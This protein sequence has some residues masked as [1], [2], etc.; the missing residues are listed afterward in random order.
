MRTIYRV[1]AALSL[2]LAAI[3]CDGTTTTTMPDMKGLEV[4]SSNGIGEI[5][6][7]APVATVEVPNLTA[8]IGGEGVCYVS[9]STGREQN[10]RYRVSKVLDLSDP[11]NYE[12]QEHLVDF[13]TEVPNKSVDF[14]VGRLPR[15][16]CNGHYQIDC[17]R[18]N[19]L[20]TYKHLEISGW[21]CPSPRPTPTPTPPSQCVY[22][23]WVV[24]HATEWTPCSEG[25]STRTVTYKRYATPSRESCPPEYK[26]EIEVR[27]CHIEYGFCHVSNKGQD[28][29][30]NLVVSYKAA[31]TG[32][33]LHTDINKFCPPDWAVEIGEAPGL[34]SASKGDNSCKLEGNPLTEKYCSCTYPDGQTVLDV[35]KSCN[36]R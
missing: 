24:D 15:G 16:L 10:I 29:N 12:K 7:L 3:A 34:Q 23:D 5:T 30:W 11:A 9:N 6:T 4:S 22:G 25:M 21:P 33:E 14:P 36:A 8:W 13:L 2:A 1:L 32:H 35:A 18:G 27:Q 20:L 19:G 26:E 31:G 28:G 17:G